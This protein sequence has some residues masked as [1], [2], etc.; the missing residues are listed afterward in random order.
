MNKLINFWTAAF[1]FV[2][3]CSKLALSLLTLWVEHVNGP[4]SGRDT[5]C[6]TVWILFLLPWGQ[7]NP[8]CANT[9]HI[10]YW[11]SYGVESILSVIL[12]ALSSSQVGWS[13]SGVPRCIHSARNILIFWPSIQF[14]C[15]YDCAIELLPGMVP[16][17]G[18]L[19]YHSA[20][21][22]CSLPTVSGRNPPLR[23]SCYHAPRLRGL[24][25][26]LRQEEGPL[27]APRSPDFW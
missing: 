14:Q 11:E 25:S 7:A 4:L 3:G 12:S 27:C 9:T 24:S 20:Q 13:I 8:G 23:C 22:R 10:G 16:P 15:H 18:H 5:Q 1:R 21:A 19:Y 26:H 6:Q 17:N 2:T